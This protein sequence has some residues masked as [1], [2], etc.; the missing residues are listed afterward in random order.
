M[1]WCSFTTWKKAESSTLHYWI[2]LKGCCSGQTSAS[3]QRDYA[4]SSRI[5]CLHT[6]IRVVFTAK[7]HKVCFVVPLHASYTAGFGLKRLL[8]LL[9]LEKNDL[10]NENNF[11]SNDEIKT[12]TIAYFAELDKSH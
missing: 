11:T 5:I 6:K 7:M 1:I 8:P 12:G 3:G 2:E 4:L 10:M 9:K